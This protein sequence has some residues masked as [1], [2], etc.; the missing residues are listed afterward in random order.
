MGASGRTSRPV[1][2][3]RQT[4]W[5]ILP[6]LVVTVV[7]IVSVPLFYR[8][9]GSEMYALWLYVLTFTG[10]F[11]FMDLG[12]G[13]AV[14]RYMGVAIGQGNHQAVREYW[15]TGNAI[16]IPLLAVMAAGFTLVGFFWGPGWFKVS[17][18]N[19]ALLRWS[20]VAGG[21]G[22]FL[23]YYSQFWLILSQTHLDFKF[24][25]ILRTAA[26]LIQIVPSIP[27]AWATGN[28]LILI[29]WATATSGLQLAVFVWH[30]RKHY[31]LGFSFGYAA[32]ARARDMALYTSK[33]FVTL[34]VNSLLGSADRLVLG[35]LAPPADF[36]HYAICTN[37]GGRIQGL[38]GAIM[39]PVFSHTNRA[40]GG[41]RQESF[42]AIYDETFKFT[43]PWYAL[44]SIW[45][46]IWHPVLLR[47][48][49][50]AELGG[51]VAP[52]FAPI[53]AACSLTAISTISSAQ[54]GSLNR[55][56]T[57]LVF[58]VGTGLLLIVGIYFGWHWHGVV[59]VAWGFLFSR[60]VVVAQD[61]YVMRLIRAG[62]WL[63]ASTWRHL[64]AQLI[65]AL[66]FSATAWL[67]PRTSLWQLLPAVVHG[68][69]VAGWIL[70]RPLR[71]LSLKM[72]G[73]M[74]PK[75]V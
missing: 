31:Q 36:A 38:S 37:V 28:P 51:A 1:S 45:A 71:D 17:A 35:R 72:R 10:I 46:A 25:A 14:G 65:V 8:Y 48:W 19:V 20:F 11:G 12:L 21:L 69:V 16:A 2:I 56:G 53:I 13:V 26:S 27:L 29:L 64:A 67:G 75:V 70:R 50:G 73:D 42:A 34:L 9:L 15:G 23:A 68:A 18:Q 59:G 24:L 61:L 30:A 47:L 4:L 43:F 52:L 49:L 62:G 33:T 60:A 5:S 54:L 58:T 74:S 32:W 57:G 3:Q 55:L 22:L 63:A 44:V 66:V 7:N 41:G 40:V 6:L 39:G